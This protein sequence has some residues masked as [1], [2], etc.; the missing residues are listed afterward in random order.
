M[1]P[2][3]ILPSDPLAIWRH[4]LDPK[5]IL[6]YPI[7]RPGTTLMGVEDKLGAVLNFL[8]THPDEG[9]AVATLAVGFTFSVLEFLALENNDAPAP[10]ITNLEA[11]RLAISN[12][13]AT[14]RGHLEEWQRAA[15]GDDEPD[16]VAQ[17]VPN[18]ASVQTLVSDRPHGKI[19]TDRWADLGIGIGVGKYYAFPKCPE[20]GQRLR[21]MDAIEILLV[22][23]RW[24][25]VLECLAV[26]R[27]GKT[28][29]KAELV[30]RLGYLK[31]GDIP[32]DFARDQ[33]LTV[34]NNAMNKLRHTMADLARELRGFID[35]TDKTKVF[36]R[37]G[38]DY[39]AAFTTR[40]LLRDDDGNYSFGE[41]R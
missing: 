17:D 7:R 23:D 6:N 24:P 5:P 3:T 18:A 37:N 35:M 16:A 13:R 20:L 26:S 41:A 25:K 2:D 11:A 14:V 31:K 40:H 33:Q 10:T 32:E 12:L 21:L 22:G 29:A 15:L 39:L 1:L 30:Q 38:D 34:A 9:L 36:E 27:D 28:A 4:N 8:G 19:E